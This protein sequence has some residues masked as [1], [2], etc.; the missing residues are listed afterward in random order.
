M[1]E[2]VKQLLSC[3]RRQLIEH[4]ASSVG[5]GTAE[6][7]HLLKFLAGIERDSVVA[8]FRRAGSPD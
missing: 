1:K 2:F 8:F 3:G 5:E 7:E 6:A 4:V